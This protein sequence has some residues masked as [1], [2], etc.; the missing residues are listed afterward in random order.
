MLHESSKYENFPKQ[1]KISRT[2]LQQ[3]LL[4]LSMLPPYPLDAHLS[5]KF[6]HKL[7]SIIRIH[8][9]LELHRKANM[10]CGN[11]NFDSVDVGT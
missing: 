6:S 8:Y 9:N 1:T 3:P 10:E 5:N 4:T 2:D 11:E 7:T